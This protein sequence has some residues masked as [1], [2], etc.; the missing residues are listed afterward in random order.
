MIITKHRTLEEL[1]KIKEWIYKL[2]A[3]GIV[4]LMFGLVN[5]Y[6]NQRHTTGYLII[7]IGISL[8]GINIIVYLRKSL[9][10]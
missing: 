1:G 5:I 3:M 7:V 2:S 10:S 6:L 9:T 8:I 4:I